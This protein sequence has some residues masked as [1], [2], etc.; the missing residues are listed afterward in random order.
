[1]VLKLFFYLPSIKMRILSK[2]TFIY[3]M[4]SPSKMCYC[5]LNH[6]YQKLPLILDFRSLLHQDKFYWGINFDFYKFPSQTQ[7]H[8]GD[9]CVCC[10]LNMALIEVYSVEGFTL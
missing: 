8:I 7:C 9:I 5:H 3:I 4:Y 10:M 2:K 1:M 6:W